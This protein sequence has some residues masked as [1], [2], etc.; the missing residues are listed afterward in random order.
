MKSIANIQAMTS[1]TYLSSETIKLVCVKGKRFR[2]PASHVKAQV[3]FRDQVQFLL[4]A[5]SPPFT[6]GMLMLLPKDLCIYKYAPTGLL[7]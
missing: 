5:N 4:H 6:N 2:C 1:V 7:G 3:F